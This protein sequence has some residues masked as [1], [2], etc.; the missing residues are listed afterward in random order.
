[1]NRSEGVTIASQPSATVPTVRNYSGRSASGSQPFQPF[2]AVFKDFGKKTVQ[3]NARHLRVFK[4]GAERLLTVREV[5][6]H[7]SVSTA[8][9]YALCECSQLPHFRVS[10]AIRVACADLYAFLARHLRGG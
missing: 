5:A 10:N 4:D 1:V 2:G 7:L 9:V 6:E 3:K 8:T